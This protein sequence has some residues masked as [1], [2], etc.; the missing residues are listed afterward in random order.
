MRAARLLAA[1]AFS[2]VWFSL[3]TMHGVVTLRR[4]PIVDVWAPTWGRVVLRMVGV[5]LEIRGR[6]HLRTTSQVVICNHTSALDIPLFA[7]LGPPG[8]I[9]LG[10][11]EIRWIPGFNLVWWVT[12]GVFVDRSNPLNADAALAGVIASMNAGPRTVVLAPEGTRSRDG[13]VGRFRLGAWRVARATGSPIV[14][15]V[16]RGARMCLPAGAWL[17]S[18]GPVTIDVMEP[19]VVDEG[20]LG[21]QAD[22]L[23]ARYTAWLG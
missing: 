5:D 11:R 9:H 4:T 10:K 1:L 16:V 19:V 23:R 14:P 12:R 18:P 17:V 7:A 22:T 20:D 2:A 13:T 6:E 3:A 21:A 8:M 15:C